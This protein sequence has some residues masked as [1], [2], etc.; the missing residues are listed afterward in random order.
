VSFS[1]ATPDYNNHDSVYFQGYEMA[2]RMLD[3]FMQ[4]LTQFGARA[5]THPAEQPAKVGCHESTE[6]ATP[7]AQFHV[8]TAQFSR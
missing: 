4:Q 1:T 3:L 2:R 7:I 8:K 5:P 6:K